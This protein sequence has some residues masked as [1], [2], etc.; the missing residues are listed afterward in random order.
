MTDAP[1]PR[2]AGEAPHRLERAAESD[3]R[4]IARSSLTL[5]SRG[6]S[7]FAQ[8][9]FLVLAA[10]LL[11]VDEFASYSY[12]LVL[13]A[14]FPILSGAGVPLVASRDA[15]AGRPTPGGLFYSALPVVV[16]TA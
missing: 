14:A 16:L 2:E 7:K 13:A 15:A 9:F 10:R 6:F 1:G 4:L 5:V 8:I 11:S 3:R 12:L